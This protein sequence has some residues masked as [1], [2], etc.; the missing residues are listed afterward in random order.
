MVVRVYNV[1]F[2]L[3]FH[4]NK[5]FSHIYLKWY[6]WFR[7]FGDELLLLGVI[8]YLVQRY[9]CVTLVIE[10]P[11]VSRLQ[12]WIKKNSTHLPIVTIKYACWF[13]ET[14][15]YSASCGLIVIGWGE[16]VTDARAFPHNWWNYLLRNYPRK[17][18]WKKITLLWWFGTAKWLS[19]RLLHQLLYRWTYE[20][21]T[22]E[23]ASYER[24]CS[25][26]ERDSVVA[27]KDF[28]YSILNKYAASLNKESLCIIN[29]NPYIWS[30]E[31]EQKIIAYTQKWNY[32]RLIYIP[33]ELTIDAPMY[34]SLKKHL[35]NLIR[36][37]R[38]HHTL[39]EITTLIASSSWWIAARLHILI[40][41]DYYWIPYQP[42]V[43]QEKITKILGHA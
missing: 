41:L 13:I 32:D 42:L 9:Q 35:P 16:V 20:I 15:R 39:E 22:R 34:E 11:D 7:N 8:N 17:L 23:S 29:C 30:H 2:T 21:I 10:T 4:M 3:L 37:D 12:S 14:I 6:Y 36:Y 31:T 1:I 26:V 5:I 33:A 27:H 25:V 19:T 38:T 18:I 40:L 28:S 43:Y 24:V